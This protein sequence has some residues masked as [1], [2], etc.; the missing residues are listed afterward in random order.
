[1]ECVNV[2]RAM[3]TET[4]ELPILRIVHDISYTV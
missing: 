3:V 1:M 2:A 4:Y